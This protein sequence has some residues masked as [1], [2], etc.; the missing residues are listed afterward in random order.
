MNFEER[1]HTLIEKMGCSNADQE[2]I[3]QAF[4]LAQ[5]AHEG[6]LR[7]SGEPFVIHPL[8]VAETLVDASMDV[9]CVIAALLHD[10][11]ED[12]DI[13]YDMIA[14]RF[15]KTVADLVDGVT[16]LTRLPYATKEEE[17]MENLRKMLLAMVHD[18]RVIFIKLYDRLHNMRTLE[19]K[20]QR[21]QKDTA[22]QTMLIYAPIAHRL[23]MNSIKVEL[24]DLSLQYLDP[25]GYQEIESYLKSGSEEKTAFLSSIIQKIKA[26]LV[27]EGIDAKVQGRVK[28]TYGIYRKVYMQNKEIDQV[29]DIYAA[30]VIVD[31]I[32][33]C[34]NVLGII[35]DLFKPLPGRFKDY[36][37][38]PKPNMYQSLHTTVIGREG[39]PFEVQIRTHEMH[40]M[41]EYGIAAHWKYKHQITENGGEEKI[42][43][44]RQLLEAGQDSD[45]EEFIKSLRLELFTD[46]VF[47]FTPKGDVINLPSGAT[48]I[49][50][51]YAIHTAV[52]NKMVGAK[53]NGRIV[54]LDVA[55]RSGDI[56]EVLTTNTPHGPSRDWLNIVKTGE[57]RNKIKQWFKKERREENIERGKSE[58]EAE[59]RRNFLTKAFAQE[60][61]QQQ[62]IK[63]HNF[64]NLDDLY[65]AIGY[66]GITVRKIVNRVA[67]EAQK[68]EKQQV[69]TTPKPIRETKPT[70]GVVVEGIDNCLVK[71]A[72][73]CTPIPGD[74][75]VGFITKGFGVSVHRADCPNM[76]NMMKNP[77]N[78]DRLIN[79]SWANTVSEQFQT[80]LQLSCK[81]R[82]GI[83]ADIVLILSDMKI[84][85]VNLTARE[86]G[87]GEAL[88]Q[89]V[90]Q[91]KSA[92]QLG[93]VMVKLRKVPGVIEI[94]RNI[95]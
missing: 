71:F 38:T 77:E 67:E 5:K 21:K 81:N 19:Y 35:H 22:L 94:S 45:A 48:P 47:V 13:T 29:Y 80:A 86:L 87:D 2:R 52:G 37:G 88:V 3:R 18:I 15:G 56:V 58:L 60:E 6:Q 28:H 64:V 26:R 90:I 63:K 89:A 36:I 12:T 91:L 74:L 51:A 33:D 32:T 93:Q 84:D 59:L 50:F 9:D 57:A 41:A 68:A 46:E 75:I 43:W 24:E 11:I 66:G 40:H 34:Y 49:D 27:E 82:I 72:R 14:D 92:E 1:I 76:V 7:K 54:Q 23:G 53:V 42:A 83:L 73:C 79:V 95:Q 61:L 16:K 17:E 44:V 39:K 4:E 30:R 8:A 25:V 62:I 78:T 70:S 55:L 10:T 31:S 20:T 85:V 65:A 69:K